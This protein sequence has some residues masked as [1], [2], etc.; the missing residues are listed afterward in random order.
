MPSEAVEPAPPSVVSSAAAPISAGGRLQRAWVAI[1]LAMVAFLAAVDRNILSVLL[2]PIQKDLHVGDAAMGALTG[3]AFAVV[4]ATT[5]L[6]LAWVADRTNRRNFV[7][8]AVALWSVMTAIC[9]LASSFLQL[10]LARVGV[11]AGEAAH[12]PASMS[13]VADVFPAASRGAAISVLTIGSALGYSAGAFLAGVLNDHF[14]WQG[15]MMAVGIP[16]VIVALMLWLTVPE[17]R[18]AAHDGDERPPSLSVAEGVTRLVRIRTFVPLLLGTVFLNVA[19]LGFLGWMPAFFMRVH[20]LTATHMS[21]VFGI[22]VGLGGVLS[23][24]FAGLI[25]DRLSRRG[26]R[27]RM[28]YCVAM[29][30]I[31]IPFLTAG[32]LIDS[33]RVAVIVLM[34]FTLAAGGLTTVSS[35]TAI[36]VAPANL[37]ASTVAIIGI[38][39]SVIGGGLAPFLIGVLNDLFKGAFGDQAVRYTL[40]T[41]PLALA[42]AGV[43]FFLA[44]RTIE[45]DAAEVSPADLPAPAA[46]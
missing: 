17:P 28:H 25:S 22:V 4:F 2:V 15:A 14:G 32:L 43:M 9:G 40:L 39:V 18:R 13:I 26:M 12:G 16:G 19:F 46:R 27:W 37:R 30:L 35:A 3:T 7:A 29:V 38:A 34:G 45:A 5:A 24:V 36:S 21:A 6:P 20:H 31:A 8:I 10:L 23:N 11:A 44:G 42:V 1:M 33:T 41:S